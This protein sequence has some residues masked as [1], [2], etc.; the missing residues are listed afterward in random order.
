VTP[1][2]QIL[3]AAALK[4]TVMLVLV[5]GLAAL[6]RRA[7]AAARHTVWSS[8]FAG[9]LVLPLLAST[10]PWRLEVLPSSASVVEPRARVRAPIAEP[11]FS[12]EPAPVAPA[13]SASTTTSETST[14]STTSPT[15]LTS[16]ISTST[17]FIAL[18]FLGVT[19]VVG[20]VVLGGFVMS[21]L[22]RRSETIDEPAWDVVMNAAMHQIG[23]TTRVRLVRSDRVPMPMTSGLFRPVIVL[24]MDSEEWSTERRLAV[25]L[26]ELG[27]IRRGDLWIHFLVQAVCACYWFHPLAWSAARRLRSESERACDDLVLN[28][29]TR[30]SEY[31]DHLLQIVRRAGPV[32]APAVALPMAQRSDFEGRLLAILEPDLARRPLRRVAAF[33]TAAA[34]ALIALPLAAMSP[35]RPDYATAEMAPAATQTPTPTPTPHP[36][37]NL[38]GRRRANTLI[39]VDARAALA[40]I[41]NESVSADARV[42]V[43]IDPDAI[44]ALADHAL[45][46]VT[47]AIAQATRDKHSSNPAAIRGLIEALS[48]SDVEVRRSAAH[49]LASTEDSAAVGALMEALRR[50]SDAEVRKTCAWALGQLEDSRAVAALV[51]A[52][53]TDKDEEVR[54]QA[55]WALGQIE[56]PAAI[57]GLGAA[58]NDA[59]QEVRKTAVWALGQIEDARAVPALLPFL[60][61][62]NVEI[63]KT[64]VWAL[65]QIESS[66]AVTG[67]TGLAKDPSAEVRQQVAWA[68]GQIQNASAVDALATMLKDEDS[69][70]RGTA[71]WALGQIED[72]R[73]VAALAAALKDANA[74][75]RSKAAWALGQ[76]GGHQAPQALID[77]T[78]DQNHEVRKN[79]AWAL[80]QIEDAAAVP[81]LILLLKDSDDEVKK[82]AMWA[83]GQIDDTTALDA[84]VTLL[85]DPDPQVRRAAAQALG[86]NH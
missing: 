11:T 79:V 57:D 43:S 67:L 19:L 78:K 24:P 9:L 25:L 8:G 23:I 45:R 71:A 72:N 80:G 28:S 2:I 13:P 35:T 6:L 39:D 69:E 12:Y 50:D 41:V 68:L 84:M 10:L 36:A 20:R 58:L 74:E 29:G 70:V 82:N 47:T 63:R 38:S 26:H 44:T 31:A 83:L 86:R 30:A 55:A 53:K 14:T 51:E 3:A 42:H 46:R 62:T 60:K 66:S 21:W 85:K 81:A 15:S 7:S 59:S 77:A 48:D 37:P 17:L 33:A 1:V 76:I 18:W 49:A 34:V 65:G 22:G 64:A 54:H 73:S 16:G 61:D 4:A 27:H 52:L 56:S 32:H 5:F 75:V 40:A